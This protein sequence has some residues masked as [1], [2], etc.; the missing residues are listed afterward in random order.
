MR[1]HLVLLLAICCSVQVFGNNCQNRG[2]VESAENQ[3]IYVYDFPKGKIIDTISYENN[4]SWFVVFSLFGSEG[5]YLNVE[6]GYTYR[7]DIDKYVSGWVKKASYIGTL[8]NNYDN[9]PIELLSKPTK[10][11]EVTSV[12]DRYYSDIFQIIDCRDDWLYVR[13]VYED[14]IFEG[15]LDPI[16]NCPNPFTY[17]N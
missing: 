16:Y 15:W 14:S 3:T 9:E 10:N 4:H 13:L 17:C 11:S 1:Q 5:D 12:V 6:I 7:P 8:V 2:V